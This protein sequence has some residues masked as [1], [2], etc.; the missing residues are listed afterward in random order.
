M[1]FKNVIRNK[2]KKGIQNINIITKIKKKKNI[3]FQKTTKN[4]I[5]IIK[6]KKIIKKK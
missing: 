5:I 4:K 2:E 6:T 1:C 3:T